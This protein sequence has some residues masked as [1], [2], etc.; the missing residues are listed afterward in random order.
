MKPC[1]KRLKNIFCC[2]HCSIISIVSVQNTQKFKTLI[3]K[4]GGW[5]LLV[6][7]LRSHS[8]ATSPSHFS[9][10]VLSINFTHLLFT[11]KLHL[12]RSPAQPLLLLLLCS[13]SIEYKVLSKFL[14]REIH[15]I[16]MDAFGI[17]TWV[18]PRMASLGCWLSK[19]F[20]EFKKLLKDYYLL[21]VSF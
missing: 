12:S 18:T 11:V 16:E 15:F 20:K 17:W 2:C 21:I 3:T 8:S 1:D 4:L 13:Y 19:S 7:P 10:S 9:H 5:M 6:W 14:N